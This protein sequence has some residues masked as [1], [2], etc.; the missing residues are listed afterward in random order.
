MKYSRDIY[1]SNDPTIVPNPPNIFFNPPV[2]NGIIGCSTFL[3]NSD[4]FRVIATGF[5][6]LQLKHLSRT[7]FGKYIICGPPKSTEYLSNLSR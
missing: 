2:I 5:N 4:V 6:R 7:D 3:T 1:M